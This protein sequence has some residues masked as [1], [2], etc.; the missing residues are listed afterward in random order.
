MDVFLKKL[1]NNNLPDYINFETPFY[2]CQMIKR[3]ITQVHLQ[4]K[5]ILQVLKNIKLSTLS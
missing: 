3:Y 5:N 1:L 4:L 2:S